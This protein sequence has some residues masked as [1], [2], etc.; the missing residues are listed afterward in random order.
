MNVADV[1][2]C[3]LA[4]EVRD[5]DVVGVGLGTPL[6][7]C[8]C[9]L[10]R[11]TGAPG[12]SVLVAGAVSPD[13]TLLDCLGGPAALAGRTAGFVPHLDTMDM[14][15]RQAMTLQFLR[16]AQVG[17]DGSANTSRVAAGGRLVR[18]PGGL[19]T[20][21][22]P[23]LLPRL[24]YYHT[25]HEPRALPPVLGFR[26]AAGGGIERAG[27]RARGPVALVTDRCVIA[28]A[29]TGPRLASVHEGEDAGAVAAATGFALDV[30]G[31]VPTTRGPTDS[32]LAALD[33]IDPHRIRELEFRDLRAA[34]EERL[35]GL[36]ATERSHRA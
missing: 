21:D 12:A 26:T 31:D 35:R 5:G 32:E 22:V 2:A 18:F 3:T 17:A 27:Y 19:A 13:A 25:A 29:E 6:A 23:N 30:P 4:R 7:L 34:A 1:V 8:A 9:L 28:F 10:A 24:V 20:A 15:E 16:P 14:A 36:R 33:E 11:R